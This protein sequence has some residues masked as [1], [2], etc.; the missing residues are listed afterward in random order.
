MTRVAYEKVLVPALTIKLEIARGVSSA[1]IR[2]MRMQDVAVDSVAVVVAH[3]MHSREVNVSEATPACSPMT[4]K[5]VVEQVETKV[6]EA[7][8]AVADHE[9]EEFVLVIR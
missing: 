7:G 1:S 9:E 8:G 2:M 6:E 3:V 4:K 5:V